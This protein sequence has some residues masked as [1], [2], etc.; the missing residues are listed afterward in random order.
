MSIFSTIF[1]ALWGLLKGLFE[2]TADEFN[3]LPKE[4]Q[5][6][7]L[8]GTQ[9]SQIIKDNIGRSETYVIDVIS[10]RLNISHDIAQGLFDQ[11]SKDLGFTSVLGGIADKIGQGITDLAHNALFDNIAKFAAVF[12]G[13]GSVSWITL[14]LGTIEYAYQLLK[15]TDKLIKPINTAALTPG[16]TGGLPPDPT[17]PGH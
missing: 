6:A 17:H 7:I 8:N 14:A 2:S 12:L 11:L 5:D 1:G 16:D 13:A 9:V 15:G 10:S 4:Q 3:K